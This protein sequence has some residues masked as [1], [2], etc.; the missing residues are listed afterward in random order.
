MSVSLSVRHRVRLAAGCPV[1]FI[2]LLSMGKKL[3]TKVCISTPGRSS[4]CATLTVAQSC[5]YEIGVDAVIAVGSTTFDSI[6]VMHTVG[7]W[8]KG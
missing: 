6:L 7:D 8:E 5:H 3:K 2:Y 4:A 1:T